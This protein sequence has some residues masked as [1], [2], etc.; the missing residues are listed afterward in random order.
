[1]ME[2]MLIALED[3]SEG[4]GVGVMMRGNVV[5]RRC[6]GGEPGKEMI[7]PSQGS[8]GRCELERER[9]EREEVTPLDAGQVARGFQYRQG[10]CL[11]CLSYP[12]N[13]RV[14]R[15]GAATRGISPHMFR[16]YHRET[17]RPLLAQE[18][19]LSPLNRGNYWRYP[20]RC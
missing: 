7:T 6:G 3:G 11:S 1:M 15:R 20:C 14:P 9:E 10:N 12:F 2:M 8:G 16:W 18:P 19:S 5:H 17:P 4:V 13:A